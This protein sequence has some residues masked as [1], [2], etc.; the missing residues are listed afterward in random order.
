MADRMRFQVEDAQLLFRN[1]SGRENAMNDAGKRNFC[2]VLDPE[3]AKNMAKDGWNV[4]FPDPRP[5]AEEDDV[6]DPYIQVA[7][8]F[9][10]LPPRIVVITSNGRKTLNEQTVDML[11]GV[12]IAQADLIANASHWKVGNKSG[13]KAYLKSLFITLDEDDLERKYSDIPEIN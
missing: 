6:R 4:K 1:F 8:R 2:V 3:A 11:D 5:G 7:L 9:D 13:I 10:I 12:D